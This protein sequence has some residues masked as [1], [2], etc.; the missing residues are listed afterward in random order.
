MMLR[1]ASPIY[2]EDT[3]IMK[4][5]GLLSFSLG[6]AKLAKDIAN[7]SLPAGHSCPGA[8]SCLAKADRETGRITDGP[9]S[10]Y[11]CFS[12][13]QE[14]AFS[15]VRRTRWNNFDLLRAAHTRTNM[16][17]LIFDSMPDPKRWTKMRIHVSGDFFSMAYFQAW[18]DVAARLSSHVFYAY[19]KSG[20]LVDKFFE[21]GGVLPDNFILTGSDGG[22][23]DSVW[24][25]HGVKM[26]Y[27]VHHPDDTALQIDHTDELAYAGTGDFALLLHGQQPAGSPAA[28]A[29]ARLSKEGIAFAYGKGAQTS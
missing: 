1:H 7:F 6:N 17:E 2:I 10:Q 16:R 14:A 23:Q 21:A 22:K 26:A 18:I 13:S 29:A 5:E 3:I 15:N 4:K 24:G 9:A 8:Q 20:S 28:A 25:K 27:V 12:A 11:R 19:T